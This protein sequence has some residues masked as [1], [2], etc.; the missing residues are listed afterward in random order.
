MQA[1]NARADFLHAADK[2]KE[3][4][5]DLYADGLEKVVNAIDT[6]LAAKAPNAAYADRLE[7]VGRIAYKTL[8]TPEQR[9]IRAMK[10]Q[11]QPWL[12][13]QDLMPDVSERP[14]PDEDEVEQQKDNAAWFESQRQG[15]TGNN[16]IDPETRRK[17]LAALALKKRRQAAGD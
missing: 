11:R 4:Y 3:K 14:E 17:A 15:R 6:D 1:G 2:F 10:L 12:K 8:G 16:T 9:A 7:A 5:S 13:E